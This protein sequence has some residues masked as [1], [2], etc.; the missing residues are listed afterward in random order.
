MLHLGMPG[1]VIFIPDE[2]LAHLPPV[3]LPSPD[4]PAI[5]AAD[6]RE[7]APQTLQRDIYLYWRFARRNE[8]ALTTRGLVP[9]RLLG[10][11]AEGLVVAEDVDAVAGEQ[12]L[13]RPS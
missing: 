1:E 3:T 4:P 11:I 13:A 12:E 2:V 6:I 7:A 10:K 5:A 9:K 8:L